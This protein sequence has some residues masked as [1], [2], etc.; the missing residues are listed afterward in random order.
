MTT[1][2]KLPGLPIAVDR[3]AVDVRPSGLI[4]AS[5]Y[6]LREVGKLARRNLY[7]RERRPARYD[8]KTG[9]MP[10][11]GCPDATP[12]EIVSTIN[13]YAKAVLKIDVG[14]TNGYDK[15][16]DEYT[17]IAKHGR[18][19]KPRDYK[20]PGE[21]IALTIKVF[22]TS[23]GFEGPADPLRHLKASRAI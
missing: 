20:I 12:F 18:W 23:Q 8:D 1:M 22:R 19:E 14:R 4:I 7:K 17:V 11:I 10:P 16:R 3:P 2:T 13:A 9:E 6:K 21:D 5:G 15:Q